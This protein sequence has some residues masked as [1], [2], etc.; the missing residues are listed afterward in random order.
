MSDPLNALDVSLDVDRIVNLAQITIYP[1]ETA[2]AV[3]VIWTAW[4]D[5]HIAP[6]TTRVIYG[7][8]R[9]DNGE[10]VGATGVVAPVS[11]TD[12]IYEYN[13]IDVTAWAV[14][15]VTA[16]IEATRVKWELENT[17]GWATLDVT[18]LQ[19]RGKP[20]RVYDP[21][22][23]EKVDSTSQTTYEVRAQR[24][25][26]AM[27]PDLNFAQSYTEYLIGRFAEPMLV[28]SRIVIQDRPV[29]EGVNVFSLGLMDKVNVTDA[30]T[31]LSGAGHWIR[32]VE[33]DI[34]AGGNFTATFHLERADDRVYC[35]LDKAGYCELDSVRVGF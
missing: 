22:S 20:T 4:D 23:F 29:I 27:Q 21:I 12:Y 16:T 17:S 14:L 25:D 3:Q 26:L 8:F 34:L 30:E 6:G 28:A 15:T 18:T 5:L 11:G 9:D 7:N 24:F 19:V 1:V 2:G 13:G 10:R 35:F 32:A 33:Y 31:G